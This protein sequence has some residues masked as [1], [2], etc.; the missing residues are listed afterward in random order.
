MFVRN[1]FYLLLLSMLILLKPICSPK[2]KSFNIDK[3]TKSKNLLTDYQ[4]KS[5]IILVDNKNEKLKKSYY[6]QFNIYAKRNYSSHE[7]KTIENEF[8]FKMLDYDHEIPSKTVQSTIDITDIKFEEKYK[9]SIKSILMTPLKLKND[10]YKLEI[11]IPKNNCMTLFMFLDS[12]QNTDIIESTEGNHIYFDFRENADNQFTQAV[13]NY[14][15]HTKESFDVLYNEMSSSYENVY[16]K[17][18][19]PFYSKFGNDQ[20]QLEIT[21][22]QESYFFDSKC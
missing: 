10:F 21:K 14:W 5:Q 2:G 19:C 16:L 12:K 6:Y 11:N 1:Y 8:I 9:L 18:M 20:I 22:F 13:D 17:I 15:A 7:N 4:I 3:E